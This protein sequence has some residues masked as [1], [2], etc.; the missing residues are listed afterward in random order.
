MVL[1]SMDTVASWLLSLVTDM[2]SDP[3]T[4]LGDNPYST[5][6]EWQWEYAPGDHGGVAIQA[7]AIDDIKSLDWEEISV[8]I[9]VFL[10]ITAKTSEQVKSAV[11]VGIMRLWLSPESLLH[12]GG[13]LTYC[14]FPLVN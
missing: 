6:R 7:V 13:D 14:P 2:V 8:R 12:E 9:S 11:F 1:S 3:Y 10:D 4:V 5:S